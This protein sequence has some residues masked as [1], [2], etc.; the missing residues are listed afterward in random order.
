MSKPK[1]TSSITRGVVNKQSS[2][3]DY[4]TESFD[5]NKE[6]ERLVTANLMS[7]YGLYEGIEEYLKEDPRQYILKMT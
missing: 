6:L 4:E 7:K 2:V 5:M 1:V 3:L